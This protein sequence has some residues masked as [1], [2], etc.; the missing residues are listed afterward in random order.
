V[1][2]NNSLKTKQ[3]KQTE[4]SWALQ[5]MPLI[6]ALRRHRQ[7]DVLSVRPAWST[8]QVPGQLGLHKETLS[9]KTKP[10]KPTKI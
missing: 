5:C 4:S 8:E 3:T 7:V 1:K 10:N 9:P 6:P 2:E